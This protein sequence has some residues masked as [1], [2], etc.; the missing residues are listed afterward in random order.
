MFP[1]AP[2]K[3]EK[4]EFFDELFRIHELLSSEDELEPSPPPLTRRSSTLNF[5]APK[6]GSVVAERGADF[7][8]N[9]RLNPKR[10]IK[11]DICGQNGARCVNIS[12]ITH[13]VVDK[14]CSYEDVL[15]C[16]KLDTLPV[17]CYF[18]C[19]LVRELM[20]FQEHI[21]VV[22]EDYPSDCLYHRRIL[23]P[24]QKS[25]APKEVAKSP[26]EQA[27]PSSLQ[28]KPQKKDTNATQSKES[29]LTPPD[30]PLYET[31]NLINFPIPHTSASPARS[32]SGESTYFHSAPD[33]LSQSQSF[34]GDD[35][36]KAIHDAKQMPH[37]DA[38]DHETASHTSNSESDSDSESLP[39]KQKSTQ[40]RRSIANFQCLTANDGKS[41]H[42][43]PNAKAIEMLSQ[44]QQYYERTKDQWR[45]LSYRKAIIALKNQQHKMCFA[46]DARL[47]PGIGK[48]I[49]DKIEEIVQTDSLRRLEFANLESRDTLLKLFL[50]V[51][52]VGI[53]QA[54]KWIAAGYKTL[55]D[56][57][58]KAQLSEN[59]KIGIEYYDDFAL[60][61]P[62]VEVERH[63]E[64]VAKAAE[65]ID[66]ALQTEV[67]G[68]YRRGAETCGDVSF[69]LR[70]SRVYTDYKLM[71]S[72]FLKCALAIPRAHND[73]SK[74][75]GASALD[76]S[77]PWR[78]IDFLVVPWAER[79]AALLYFTG[80]DIFNRS[81]RLLASKKGYRLNQR[82]LYKDAV[83]GPKRGRETKGALVEGADEKKIFNILGV[84]YRE[85]RDRNC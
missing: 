55:E 74:W 31:T 10:K 49:A 40:S 71:K 9:N 2:F 1:R 72:G 16:L 81:L 28:I 77:S 52:G 18:D 51:Y 76:V 58:E 41:H 5:S 36:E 65:E 38:E 85:P 84:P 26:L 13:L 57:R 48:R 27:K 15:R 11:M 60:S 54:N 75:H 61:I 50:G 21:H 20:R 44:M 66:T 82:G 22:K 80:N 56:L 23:D 78:R 46:S 30:K 24:K 14:V 17:G 83:R 4:A 37:L 3:A 39:K 19:R 34:N 63:G 7:I 64:I 35:L 69:Q 68:S 29:Q 32:K 62:R 33:K 70:W 45:A 79:G 25:P 12:E 67:M 8:P 43:N 73:G 6:H 53:V 59:Q 47:I 42:N